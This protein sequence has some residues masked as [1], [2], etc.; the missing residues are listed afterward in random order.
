MRTSPTAACEIDA[1]VEPLDLRRERAVVESIERYRRF[2]HDHPN[3]VL[4]EDWQPIG[5]IQQRSPM[6]AALELQT[7]FNLPGN[8]LPSQKFSAIPPWTELK[9][10]T[11]RCS[12]L[13]PSIDKSSL[14]TVLRTCALE[15]IESYS[16]TPVQVYTDGSAFNGTTSAGCGAFLKFPTGPDMELSKPCGNPCDNYSAEI[17]GLI[18]AIETINDNFE[19]GQQEPKDIVIFT[20]SLSALKALQNLESS[21]S[22]IDDLALVIDKLLTSYD[23]KLTLQWIPGHCNLQGN[24]RADKL[25]K[26]GARKEQPDNPCSFNTLRRITKGKSREEWLRRW[27]DGDTGRVMYREMQEPNPKDDIN[28]LSR[29]H[30]S[31]IFQLRTTHSKLNYNLNRF[32]PCYTPLC[33]NCIHPYETTD[34]VLF[35]CPGLRAE[36]ERL[37]PP[38]PNISNSLYCSKSQLL[39]TAEFYYLSLSSKS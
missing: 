4:V 7:K 17:Q 13:D 10:A 39:K 29:K 30:Q 2:E 20:D 34:H 26:E 36:R 19:T 21:I 8:R 12:L 6:D 3:R 31:A 22:G 33:R 14:P 24:D 5:R 35:E 18:S 25:A 1:R 11:I 32:D 38:S 37:L 16:N 23:I 27:R 9:P 28:S 15:T